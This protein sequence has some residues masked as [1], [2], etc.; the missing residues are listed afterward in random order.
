[1]PRLSSI[2]YYAYKAAVM[3]ASEALPSITLI[4]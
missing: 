4:E 2:E 1:M 3:S